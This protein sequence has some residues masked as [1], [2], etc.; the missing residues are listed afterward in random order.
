MVAKET[1][2][3]FNDRQVRGT[4]KPLQERITGFLTTASLRALTRA[5][6]T[7]TGLSIMTPKSA[8]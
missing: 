8:P 3:A 2:M 1:C 7:R 6:S 5:M 4:L